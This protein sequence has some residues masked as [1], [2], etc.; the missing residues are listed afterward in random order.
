MFLPPETFRPN[1]IS[2]MLF[3]LQFLHPFQ[4][5]PEKAEVLQRRLLGGAMLAFYMCSMPSAKKYRTVS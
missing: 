3:E 4:E 1:Y 2:R 5:S